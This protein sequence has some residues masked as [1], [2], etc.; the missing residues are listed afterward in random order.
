M[1][2]LAASELVHLP[3][4]RPVRA[5]NADQ[6]IIRVDRITFLTG[7]LGLGFLTVSWSVVLYCPVLIS[8][9]GY[10]FVTRVPGAWRSLGS[11]RSWS[12]SCLA[13]YSASRV[14]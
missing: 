11:W 8:A 1:T 5:P 4:T 14:G 13:P 10:E 6:S 2:T 3:L 12:S 9:V 7:M